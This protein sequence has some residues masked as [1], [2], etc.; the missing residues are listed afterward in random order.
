MRVLENMVKIYIRILM[1][2][3]VMCHMAL[4]VSANTSHVIVAFDRAIP[5]DYSSV[6]RQKSTLEFI[7]R[8]IGDNLKFSN[9]YLSVVGYSMKGEEPN[10]DNFV[11]PYKDSDGKD[12]IWR[13][14]TS[15]IGLFPN[16]PKGESELTR[17]EFPGSMQSL[18]KPYCVMETAVQT[19]Y[20][21]SV[22]TYLIFITDEKV[23]GVDDDYAA[24]W[25]EMRYYN[26]DAYDR[27]KA[28]VFNK[29]LK[30]FNEMYRFERLDILG[31]NLCKEYALVVYKLHPASQPSIYSV[32]D[33]PS[34][35][36]IKRVR[37]GYLIDCRV[38]SNDDNYKVMD[39][40]VV[41]A[42]GNVFERDIDGNI[43]IESGK[44][45]D[46]D[47]IEIRMELQQIDKYYGGVLLNKSNCPG[48]SLHQAVKLSS[49]DKIWGVAPLLD[50]FWWWAPN[51]I[52]TAVKIWE[53]IIFISFLSI[54]IYIFRTL[55]K[56]LSIYRPSND[57]ISMN[58]ISSNNNNSYHGRK[59]T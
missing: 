38:K 18:A 15:M 17:Y 31:Q 21:Q 7:D 55:S 33:M 45:N 35:L 44:L 4:N 43:S 28:A 52:E 26:P 2:V 48:M 53:Y 36:P 42:N 3:L 29:T 19:K 9:L 20:Q 5:N 59:N 25:N 32:S 23:Q 13:K 49:E 11:I 34:P 22:H 12:V 58:I 41:G 50:V 24:E 14:Y 40:V 6:Y 57:K 51:D 47:T 16:W 56:R 8:L 10:I 1:V 39:W 54:L 37:G 30:P 46:G 27:L